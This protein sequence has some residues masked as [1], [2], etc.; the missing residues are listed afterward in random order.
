MEGAS[1]PGQL[2]LVVRDARAELSSLPN[3]LD[4]VES[5]AA[6][7]LAELGVPCRRRVDEARLDYVHRCND[8]LLER[9]FG[10]QQ[11]LMNARYSWADTL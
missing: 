1:T 2:A 9:T 8:Q 6:D 5:A 10:V 3:L 7:R 4:L 11:R